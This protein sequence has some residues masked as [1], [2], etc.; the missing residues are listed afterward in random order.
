MGRPLRHGRNGRARAGAGPAFHRDG[1]HAAAQREGR[2]NCWWK[3][4][5]PAACGWRA[6]RN[7][8]PISS[9]P[10]RTSPTST[11][12]PCRRTARKKW[13]DTRLDGMRYSMGLFLIYFGTDRTYPD[14]AHHTI[15]LTERY[16][17]LLEDIFQKK[18]PRRRFLALPPRA[19]AHR[20]LARAARLRMLL[21]ALARAASRR[22]RRLE[23]G[24]GTLR[25]R[26]PRLAGKALS[27]LAKAH[28]Q[29]N[30]LDA[31]RFREQLDAHLGSA[32]Q[33]EPILTQSAWFR[34]HNVSEDVK[35]FY[36]RRRG[37]ASRRGPARRAQQRE[38]AGAG[39][40]A[41]VL[42]RFFN[43]DESGDRS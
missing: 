1:R 12:K 15:V 7:F 10:T 2:A 22:Q 27:R 28:R 4:A 25:R 34:P 21:R 9:S 5:R 26:H 20:S 40:A 8:P 37:H 42:N 41:P 36:P 3:A 30:H 32:F 38:A 18:D 17:E 6:A 31:A 14:L 35:N 13:T 33:F 16:Q 11:R 29:Q 24:E 43:L 39:V 19:D 23:R